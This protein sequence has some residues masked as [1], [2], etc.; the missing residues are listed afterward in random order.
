[1]PHVLFCQHGDVEG[2]ERHGMPLC[3]DEAMLGTELLDGARCEVP[4]MA[5]HIVGSPV[6][7]VFLCVEGGT[8][9]HSYNQHP[10]FSQQGVQGFP[11]FVEGFQMFHDMP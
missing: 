3:H 5:G 9:G 4:Q 6:S 10:L 8:V 2:I 11:R 7:P 1:M